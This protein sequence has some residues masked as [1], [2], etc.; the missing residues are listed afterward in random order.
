MKSEQNPVIQSNSKVTKKA[1][2]I[3]V[4]SAL[5]AASFG[6][7]AVASELGLVEAY[8]LALKN[9]PTFTQAELQLKSDD[10]SIQAIKG[11][12]YPQVQATGNHRR[13]NSSAA[14]SDVNSTEFAL[15]LNQSIYQQDIWARYDQSKTA[16]EISQLGVQSAKQNLIL[17]VAD[18][19]FQVLLA[20]QNLTLF[21]TKEESDFTQ[22]ESA[23]ASV[24]VG[25]ASR[26]DVLQAKSSYDL[27]RSDRI[28]AENALDIAKEN[29]AKIIGQNVDENSLKQLM[30]Q[31]QVPVSEFEADKVQNQAKMNNL[32]VRQTQA[33]LEVAIKEIEVQKAAYWPSFSMQASVSDTQYS[34]NDN[35]QDRND[36][37]VNF[38]VTVPIYTGGAT[39]ANVES[40]RYQKK[41]SQEQ[42]RDAVKSAKL[43]ARTQLR[44]IQKG[45]NLIS[46]LREAVKSND[47][48]LE[49]AEEGYKVGL[50]DLL[51]V[52]SA[53]AN[54]VQARKNLIEAMHNQ[55]LNYL[56]L[57]AALGDLNMDDLARF[58]A[59][60]VSEDTTVK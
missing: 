36:A 31:A 25:L 46:A 21:K 5:M 45:E 7:Q 48:F 29:L 58:N 26:V 30:M 6:S 13:N 53:R 60:L 20:K 2:L 11:A 43:E 16:L 51:E 9:D 38:N 42:L 14:S 55:I 50:K 47:A 52:L 41:I 44:N 40:S 39:N 49:A 15:T 24:E 1:C 10:Q 22:L 23:K 35:Y 59:L 4:T 57:E 54:Q 3:A 19:Y 33:Q 37:S 56:R 18:A 34:G 17:T 28:S 32:A 8:E 12:L 27:S